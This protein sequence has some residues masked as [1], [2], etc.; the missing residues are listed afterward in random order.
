M[1][2]STE[3]QALIIA[4]ETE[5]GEQVRHILQQAGWAATICGSAQQDAPSLGPS[6]HVLIVVLENAGCE[7]SLALLHQWQTE[8][9][10][11]TAALMV[12]AAQ[13]ASADAMR[14]LQQ[15]AMDYRRW[16]LLPSE[17]CALA[18]QVRRQWAAAS[19]GAE[20]LS[21][22]LIAKESKTKTLI[23]GS[24]PMLEL[25]RQL[26]KVA[27]APDLP[28]FLNGETGTGKEVVA[29]QIHQL[30]RRPGAFRAINC[31]AMVE[32]LLESELFGHEKG[33]FTGAHAMKKG[34]WE[35]AAN[36]TI[37]LDE[38]TEAT[39]T[40]QAKLLRVLQE[41]TIRRIGSNH[42]IQVTARIIAASNRN[43]SAA[44]KDGLFR[45]DLYY[46]LGQVIAIPPL[47]ERAEDIPLLLA[48]FI[49]RSG[50]G[51]IFTDE[52]LQM[53]CRHPWP[54]NVRE[55]ESVV[56]KLV[57]YA[58]KYISAEDV[59]RFLSPHEMTTKQ[60]T[61]ELL[62]GLLLNQPAH[63]WPTV[64]ELRERYIIEA[65]LRWGRAA[66]VARI[67]SIDYRTVYQILRKANLIPANAEETAADAQSPPEIPPS[68]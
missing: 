27:S 37:F 25:S 54:G 4:A 49:E 36:G 53:L 9:A 44:V 60:A 67:L 1:V 20:P 46:R 24:R 7:T 18:E 68:C 33:A 48:H 58:G 12:F 50:K 16:P 32:N 59:A 3:P 10:Q 56:Q 22:P 62:S 41:N 2:Q 11:G 14:C 51:I 26:V 63:I 15:G 40:M 31:A 30:S 64:H 5:H 55:L 47:R 21:S 28:V 66:Q 13:P 29:W 65:W 35:E 52:A 43:L 45:E 57:A 17:V 42:E 8:T 38:I 34:L 23:G 61:Q 19:P 39:P 6:D